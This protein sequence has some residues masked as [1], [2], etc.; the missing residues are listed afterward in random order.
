MDDDAE[1]VLPP[2]ELLLHDPTPEQ[3]RKIWRGLVWEAHRGL[4]AGC[5]GPENVVVL[6]IVPEEAGGKLALENGTTICRVCQ[7]AAK[8]VERASES[9]SSN[10]RPINIWVGKELYERVNKSLASGQ[11][12]RSMGSLV[13]FMMRL[14]A[15]EP[16]RFA[17]LGLYQDHGTDVKINLWVER[18]VYDEFKSVL[19]T[20]DMTVTDAIK[21]LL[22]VY[23]SDAEPA[24]RRN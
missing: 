9:G 1:V 11:G 6:M 17:D 16:S 19:G 14:V 12:F 22:L 13:R 23:V 20:L 3:K 8:A 10:R 24:F 21:G 4:C 7:V 18:P 2:M 5:G 15:A